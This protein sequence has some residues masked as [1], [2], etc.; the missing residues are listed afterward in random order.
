M[1]KNNIYI[2]SQPIQTGKTSLL[3][4]WTEQQENIAGI[5]T[6]D[7]GGKRKLYDIAQKRYYNLQL[8]EHDEGVRIG[9]FVFDKGVFNYAQ[10]VIHKSV[11]AEPDWLIIDEAGRLE[12]DRNEGLEPAVSETIR[13]FRTSSANTRLL[14]VIRDYLL[15][16][17]ITHYGLQ[18]AVVLD[19]TFFESQNELSGVVLCG[20]KS[21]R[22]GR[23]KALITYHNN[24]QYA[25]IAALMRPYCK[26]VYI[27]CRNDQK[28]VFNEQHQVITD[29]ATFKDA[30]PL[31]GV[32]SAFEGLKNESLLVI[33][34]DYPY[35]TTHDIMT[36]LQAR[37]P[38][39][40]VVCYINSQSGFEEPLLAVYEKQCARLLTDFYHTGQTS[41]RH[42]LKTV[43][44]KMLPGNIKS[45][46]S[47][48]TPA[49]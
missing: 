15:N 5:L 7:V 33:G 43:N 44:T 17:A 35:F 3:M 11:D 21:V 38:G 25:H 37:Q 31:T 26:Q 23:D 49:D 42:F 4:R 48:D 27:S 9:R 22:M 36:L 40:D 47:I 46:T 8:N 13:H 2:L 45:I 19:R 29:S 24:P 28:T 32:L 30:G 20:G 12:I 1:P 6:P 14:L 16:D 39:V 18:D 34:C 41:L 10:Q